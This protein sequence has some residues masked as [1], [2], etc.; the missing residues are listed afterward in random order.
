MESS[1]ARFSECMRYRYAL[2]RTWDEATSP[3]TFVMLNPSTANE[4]DNDPTVERCQQRA[5]QM[6]FGGVRVANIFAL[7]S[8]DPAALYM[9]TDPVGAEN[10][11]AILA[12]CTGAGMVICAWGGHGKF[13]DRGAFVAGLIRQVGITP[14]ALHIN[15][16]GTPKHPLY[17]GYSVQ[18][19]P[20]LA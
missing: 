15:Q 17:V 14:H 2:W 18:P 9:D 4:V 20:M 3:L 13:K 7:R 10:D 1:G 6:G 19:K 8:T 12:A 11:A 5:I 16:D